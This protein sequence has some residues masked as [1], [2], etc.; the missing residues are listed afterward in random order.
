MKK[1]LCIVLIAIIAL[2]GYF[3]ISDSNGNNTKEDNAILAKIEQNPSLYPVYNRLS[4]EEKEAYIKI[5]TA[6]Q[7]FDESVGVVYK[8]DAKRKIE[9]FNEKLNSN[10]YREIAY[11]HPEM[12]W[13][14][15]YNY[16][17][18]ITM[19]SNNEY[20]LSIKPTYLFDKETAKRMD[21]SFQRKIDEIVSVA[22]TKSNTY[23]QVLYVHDYILENCVYDKEVIEK[24][25]YKSPSINAYGCLVDGKA[26]CS[27]YTMAFNTIMKRLGY[28]IGVEFNSYN[29]FSIFKNG[30]VWNYCNLD[31]EYYYFDLTWDDIDPLSDFMD[32][33]VPY[34]HSYF[35]TTTDEM[36]KAHLKLDPKAPTP[37][38]NGTKYNYFNYNNINFEKIRLRN[39]ET[40]DFKPIGREV[41]TT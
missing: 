28:E 1:F 17:A 18:T 9:M 16:E 20:F 2:V 24:G 29:G 39:R 3:A 22:E 7:N 8:S 13:Y 26:I 5:C 35:G 36:T 23:E 37:V 11:E 31:G 30:H 6:M 38:C 21:T 27:G 40:V 34:Y 4:L 12:F 32:N 25:D 19:N 14:D 33:S 10:L 41:H 15:P